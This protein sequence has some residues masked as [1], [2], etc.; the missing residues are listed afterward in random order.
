M[1]N[2]TLVLHLNTIAL[3]TVR[4]LLTVTRNTV[5]VTTAEVGE[6]VS[7]RELSGELVQEEFSVSPSKSSFMTHNHSFIVAGHVNRQRVERGP[8]LGN[9]Q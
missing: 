5:V 4:R 2:G 9:M 1:N 8:S 7:K 6:V 3:R